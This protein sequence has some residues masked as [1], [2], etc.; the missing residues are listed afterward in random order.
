MGIKI[1]EKFSFWNNKDGFTPIDVV[2]LLPNGICHTF[3]SLRADTPLSQIKEKLWQEATRF[4]MA[5]MLRSRNQYVF[6]VVSRNGGTEELIN[7]SLSLFDI[8]PVRP[9]LKVVERQGDEQ[10]KQLNSKI[11]LLIGRPAS[12]SAKDEQVNDLRTRCMLFCNR[13]SEQRSR[14]SWERRAIYTFP[15]DFEEDTDLPIALQ[16]T[17]DTLDGFIAISIHYKYNH[18]LHKQTHRVSHK[19]HPRDLIEKGLQKFNINNRTNEKPDDYVLKELGSENY[20][21]GHVENETEIYRER[22]LI[23]YK[24]IR[25]CLL[26][27]RQI[28]LKIV[29]RSQLDVGKIERG[30]NEVPPPLPNKER[31]SNRLSLWD[32][33]PS[34]ML[35]LKV[36][37]ALN[38]MADANMWKE[39]QVG[40]FHG[41]E[42]VCESQITSRQ[43]GIHPVW[44]EYLEFKLPVSNIP[45][46]ARV[47][48]CIVGWKK[49][50]ERKKKEAVPLAW[51]NIS[52]FDYKAIM[53]QS[54]HR[55][56]CKQHTARSI[57][58]D[59]SFFNP[60]GAVSTD[61]GS[62]SK[63]LC[64]V[65][66][67]MKF[68]HTVVYPT[69]HYIRDCAMHSPERR[70]EVTVFN[71]RTWDSWRPQIEELIG[72]DA[73]YDLYDDDK[74]LLWEW[75][76]K[77][78]ELYPESLP[79]ILK[80]VKWDNHEDVK[81]IHFLLNKWNLS[82]ME[83]EIALEL[84]DYKFPDIEV[85]RL[86][87]QVL[88]SLS[89]SQ[90]E[91]YFLHLVQV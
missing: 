4:A 67:F 32:I 33:T 7:E 25:E 88:D 2:C 28:C 69:E 26:W 60:L 15:P 45:R 39:V 52:V 82:R 44:N 58:G 84:L 16:R 38:I 61:A 11:N 62:E 53:K 70:R 72:H 47:C 29:E 30:S 34:T 20:F 89:D 50:E 18:V 80:C 22:P 19:L 6:A 21:L 56:N 87:V 5:S 91:M 35:R 57:K 71:N 75:R 90:L 59:H 65:I 55:V 42:E 51:A 48:V 40:I 8:K 23:Q 43:R 83:V 74:E 31:E 3:P 9:Y 63:G 73:L 37:C 17:L 64:I 79:K 77:C 24:Y 81:E 36:H 41:G 85:R 12:T 13:I 10:L 86:A 1:L 78:L 76:E 54:T 14:A 68:A 66:D 49:R 46:M 27:D